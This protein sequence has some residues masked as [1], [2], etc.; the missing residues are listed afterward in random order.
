M[1]VGRKAV[2]EVLPLCCVEVIKVIC[3]RLYF[4]VCFVFE[5]IYVGLSFVR[6]FDCECVC[7]SLFVYVF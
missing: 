2:N 6:F 5:T 3:L 4:T 1:L 7:L